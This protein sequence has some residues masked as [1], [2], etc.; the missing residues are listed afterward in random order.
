[1]RAFVNQWMRAFVPE[2]WGTGKAHEFSYQEWG[3]LNGGRG[4]VNLREEGRRGANIMED[5]IFRFALTIISNC[6]LSCLNQIS[7]L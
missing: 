4:D 7:C 5:T 2:K 1:M 3:S 6:Q